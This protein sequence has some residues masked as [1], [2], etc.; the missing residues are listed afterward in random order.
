MDGLIRIL[1]LP[2]MVLG[3]MAQ[4]WMKQA[5]MNH[6][7]QDQNP[8]QTIHVTPDFTTGPV[9]NWPVPCYRAGLLP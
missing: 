2:G 4:S 6:P 3:G 7:G 9:S 1:I 5:V 8:D